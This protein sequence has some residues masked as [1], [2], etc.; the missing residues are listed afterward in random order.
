MVKR[1][2]KIERKVKEEGLKRYKRGLEREVSKEVK[3][4][5]ERVESE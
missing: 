1:S 3:K 4:R 5:E 2:R